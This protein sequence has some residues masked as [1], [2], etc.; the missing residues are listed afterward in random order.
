MSYR[1]K[2]VGL[3]ARVVDQV[4]RVQV[5][6][7]FVNTGSRQMEV[8]FVFPLPY[9]GGGRSDDVHGGRQGVPGPV[10]G[11]G[12]GSFDLRR[13]HSPQF[14][15]RRCWNGSA[16]ACSRRASSPCRRVL[17]G[18]SRC[19]TTRCCGRTTVSRIFLFPLKT[20]QYTSQAVEKVDIQVAI[21][22]SSEIKNVLQP[23]TSHRNQASGQASSEHQLRRQRHRPD[24]R[25]P[26]VLRRRSGGIECQRDQLPGPTRMRTG[27]SCCWPAPASRRPPMR[28]RARTSSLWLTAPAA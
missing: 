15:T 24:W 4:A 20:A 25:F 13:L 11:G 22:S 23:D 17:S 26:L 16:P 9:D 10:A 1:I 12:Q 6:Q 27:T 18:K 3:H 5:S 19:D 8:C 28:D 21:E 14:R 7:T 2:E